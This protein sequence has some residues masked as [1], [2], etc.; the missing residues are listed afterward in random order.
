MFN[1]LINTR[2]SD[3]YHIRREAAEMAHL[4]PHPNHISNGEEE[5]Y[6]YQQGPLKGKLSYIANFSKGLKHNYI[7]EVIPD[8]YRT[9]VKAMYSTDPIRF[10]RRMMMRTLNSFNLINPQSGLAF[11]LE[12]PDAQAVTMQLA[13]R[14][15]S[16]EAT[17]E[18]IR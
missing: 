10:E 8:A 5:D 17:A 6:P 12:G 3:A 16:P 11:D 7:G 13:P 9:I 2:R 18:I 1:R 14:I 15:D 4:R